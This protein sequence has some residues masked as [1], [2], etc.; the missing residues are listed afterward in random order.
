MVWQRTLLALAFLMA[1]APGNVGF[2]SVPIANAAGGVEWSMPQ[3][4]S[5]DTIPMHENCSKCSNTSAAVAACAAA[6]SVAGAALPLA[7]AVGL[8]SVGVSFCLPP[9]QQVDRPNYP[10]DPHPPKTHILV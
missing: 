3:E 8:V 2:V 10:P 9:D 7:A 1:T 6:C 4:A 5:A